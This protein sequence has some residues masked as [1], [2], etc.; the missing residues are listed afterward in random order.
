MVGQSAGQQVGTDARGQADQKASY[1]K[2]RE[3]AT[4]ARGQERIHPRNSFPNVPFGAGS[5]S[6]GEQE[7]TYY[8]EKD[9]AVKAN[10][11]FAYRWGEMEKLR[12]LSMWTE[13]VVRSEPRTQRS[14]VSGWNYR[15]LRCARVR[16]S[17]RMW[18]QLRLA[19]RRGFREDQQDTFAGVDA[20]ILK[21]LDRLSF[22]VE[23]ASLHGVDVFAALCQRR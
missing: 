11:R 3:D 18:I 12:D 13:Y 2:E 16:G 19:W 23:P 7:D 4:T 17:E 6:R 15:L 14:G 22:A 8:H 21:L 20:D 9:T 1:R 10:R 5:R